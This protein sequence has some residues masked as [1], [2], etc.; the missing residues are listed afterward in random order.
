MARSNERISDLQSY[1]KGLPTYEEDERLQE[2]STQEQ[3]SGSRQTMERRSQAE[4]GRRVPQLVSS[5]SRSPL[6]RSQS[7]PMSSVAEDSAFRR[8]SSS[9]VDSAL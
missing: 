3:Q 2:L 8:R 5:S 6:Q 1:M 9:T 7:F 4:T